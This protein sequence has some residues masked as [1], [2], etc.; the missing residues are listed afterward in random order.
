MND[1][2]VT[3]PP[4][5]YWWAR[6]YVGLVAL[7]IA[8]V[9]PILHNLATPGNWHIPTSISATYYSGARDVFVGQL[10]VV[11]AFLFSYKGHRPPDRKSYLQERVASLLCACSA[12]VVAWI[13]TTRPAAFPNKYIT[14][15]SIPWLH[16]LAAVLLIG[17]LVFFCYRFY[18]RA[19]S[20]WREDP[21]SR[22]VRRR[23]IVYRICGLGMSASILF[24]VPLEIIAGDRFPT[25]VF[26]I[27]FVCL[28][29]FGVAWLVAG[30]SLPGV[31]YFFA[32][33]RLV[34]QRLSDRASTQHDAK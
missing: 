30:K 3:P 33:D 1:S 28:T 14:I 16:Q 12:V 19:K 17:I 10:F 6:T 4:F 8:I 7:S 13:P 11:A 22:K 9:C 32:E 34:E 15:T 27:E 29:L 20:K 31:K 5:D 21:S 24:G 23:C 25:T 2:T 26:W 18:I